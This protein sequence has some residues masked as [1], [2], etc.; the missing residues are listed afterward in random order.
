MYFFWKTYLQNVQN[1][2]FTRTMLCIHGLLQKKHCI[3]L[4]LK[5]NKEY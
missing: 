5:R 3:C 2:Y 4:F 1:Y